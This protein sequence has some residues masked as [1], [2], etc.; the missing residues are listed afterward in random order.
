M[1]K[2]FWAALILGASCALVACSDDDS[3]VSASCSGGVCTCT[4]SGALCLFDTLIVCDKD[5]VKDLQECAEDKCNAGK[6]K[7][8]N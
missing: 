8:N 1:K 6:R 5:E 4:G 2:A 3:N 7:C